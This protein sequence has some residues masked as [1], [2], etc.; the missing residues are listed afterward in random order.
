MAPS[1]PNLK[2]TMY[3]DDHLI[4]FHNLEAQLDIEDYRS[5]FQRD[6]ARIIHS[7]SFRRLK[8]KTQLYPDIELDFFRNR[9]THSLEVAQIA[10]SITKKINFKYLEKD[11]LKID[12]ELVELS[13]LAHDLGHPPFG[14]IGEK[15]LDEKMKEHC[16]FEG[17]AQTLRILTKTEKKY[18]YIHDKKLDKRKGLNLTV[19]SLASILKYDEMIKETYEERFNGDKAKRNIGHTIS[20]GY[21]LSEEGIVNFIK[22]SLLKPYGIEPDDFTE[23]FKTI[24]CQIMDIADDIA[25]SVCDIEDAFK[26]KFINPFDMIF[27][28]KKLME[29]VAKKVTKF[30]GKTITGNKVYS[31]L[32]DTFSQLFEIIEDEDYET[33][34]NKTFYIEKGTIKLNK[35]KL[36]DLYLFN[37]NVA[38]NT[39]KKIASDGK[40]RTAFSSLLIGSFIRGIEFDINTEIPFLSKVTIE[41]ETKT[42]I[43]VLKNFIY[44]SQIRSPKMKILEYRGKHI[45]GHIFN[46]LTNR[47]GDFNDGHKLLPDDTKFLYKNCGGK[48]PKLMKERIICDFIAGMTDRYSIEFYGRLVSE[49]PV[50]I[51][52]PF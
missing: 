27:A 47:E 9:L 13:G 1:N 41:D 33:I 38:Y 11:N 50:S 34:I 42:Q 46:Q 14:H 43:E 3:P 5:E 52:K 10:K 30:L 21:Y 6:Y 19:R 17:N 32:C 7:N 48:H 44:E 45:L 28:E 23:P 22:E 12:L 15:I 25:Y 2:E 16:G 39:A 18:T 24:E 37:S 49:N 8:G 20:K 29:T 51:F 36:R 26:A 40:H 31:I 35:D 4:R